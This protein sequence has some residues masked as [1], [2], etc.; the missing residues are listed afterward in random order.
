MPDP[1]IQ[2]AI[3]RGT[4]VSERLIAFRDALFEPCAGIL[5]I[6][7][8]DGLRASVAGVVEAVISASKKPHQPQG[9]V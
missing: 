6:A 5:L 9:G 1:A 3:E 8:D 7:G 4:I 2:A